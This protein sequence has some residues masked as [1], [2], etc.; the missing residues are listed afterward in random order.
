MTKKPTKNPPS[1]MTA[2]VIKRKPWLRKKK[3]RIVAI[4]PPSPSRHHD[5]LP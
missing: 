3:P 4:S 2:H 1:P 5:V